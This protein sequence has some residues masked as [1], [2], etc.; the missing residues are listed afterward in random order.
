VDDPAG[1]DKEILLAI[2]EDGE[3]TEGY[4]DLDQVQPE[5]S[6]TEDEAGDVVAL[7]QSHI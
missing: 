3:P 6:I 1:T 2:F 7:L 5:T 4:S